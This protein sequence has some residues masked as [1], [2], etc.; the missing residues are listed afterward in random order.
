M[1]RTQITA[2]I[3]LTLLSICT[4]HAKTTNNIEY[5]FTPIIKS[6]ALSAVDVT[7]TFKGN[8]TGTTVLAL[9]DS[10]AG[11]E[12]LWRG[13][14][15]LSASGASL[16]FG[17]GPAQRVLHH[18]PNSRI[19]LHYLVVQ[20]RPEYLTDLR[21]NPYRIVVQPTYFH[22]TG[23]AALV[24]PDINKDTR[25]SVRPRSMPKA[26]SFASDLEHADTTFANVRSSISVGGDFSVLHPSRTNPT[27]RL[28]IRGVWSFDT[29]TFANR[30]SKIFAGQR[31]FWG[32]ATTPFLVTVM[33]LPEQ[34]NNTSSGGTGLG[35]A[36]AYFATPNVTDDLITETLAHEAMHTWIPALIGGLP[37]KDGELAY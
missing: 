21:N 30:L 11:E 23:N 1:T 16:D 8:S 26:W 9:P 15:N 4:A 36:F 20:E 32:D 24:V 19:K 35:D 12:E 37:E 33:Q 13:I 14:S 28:A 10:W 3:A 18:R 25:V 22:F 29:T 31:H 5:V 7:V 17:A 2:N 34:P 27:L 6:G